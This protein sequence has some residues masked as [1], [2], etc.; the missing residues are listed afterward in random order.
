VFV[1]ETKFESESLVLFFLQ[2]YS[3]TPLLAPWNGGSGF[4]LKLDLQHFLESEGKEVGFKDR[5]AVDAINAIERSD[6]ERLARYRDQIRET[7]RALAALA[8]EVDFRKALEEPLRHW[9]QAKTKA[10]RKN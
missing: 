10:A 1:L 2:Q 5:E 9:P 7:K 3:P 4:Y 6:T 8:D